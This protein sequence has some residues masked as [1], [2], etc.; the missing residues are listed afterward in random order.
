M[1]WHGCETEIWMRNQKRMTVGETRISGSWWVSVSRLSSNNKANWGT[2]YSSQE[3]KK[4]K[5]KGRGR[6][7]W[8]PDSFPN[9][10]PV[11]FFSWFIL[12]SLSLSPHWPT[13]LGIFCCCICHPYT[14]LDMQSIDFFP[15]PPSIWL[16]ALLPIRTKPWKVAWNWR[17][18]GQGC[19]QL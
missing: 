10:F 19:S 13:D 4:G 3:K 6:R 14:P 7:E 15:S 1:I 11:F 5:T 18:R 2:R 17:K 16:L 12:L 9:S 8:G